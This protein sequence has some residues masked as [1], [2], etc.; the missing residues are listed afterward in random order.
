MQEI[1]RIE[2]KI[3]KSGTNPREIMTIKKRSF[4]DRIDVPRKIRLKCPCCKLKWSYM[5]CIFLIAIIDLMVFIK[6]LIQISEMYTYKEDFPQ[7]V[8][9]EVIIKA[10]ISL[11]MVAT[12]GVFILRL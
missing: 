4:L 11:S 2:E 6:Y 5:F 3:K 10:I 9:F 8:A 1:S 7:V 12:E